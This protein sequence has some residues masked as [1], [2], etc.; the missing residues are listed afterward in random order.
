VRVNYDKKMHLSIATEAAQ[1]TLNCFREGLDARSGEARDNWPTEFR[2]EWFGLLGKL[3]P[4]V[5]DPA[6]SA[7]N[8]YRIIHTF[9]PNE[10]SQIRFHQKQSLMSLHLPLLFPPITDVRSS[11]L[12]I[13]EVTVGPSR[14]K[15]VVSRLSALVLLNQ[16]G[17]QGKP[18]IIS[19]IPFQ[20]T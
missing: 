6:F 1:A 17:Y 12:P 7:E 9:V 2:Q 20:A 16:S 13:A 14:H 18:V 4:M 11:V 15:E 3:A 8:E 5:K 10:L 19:A